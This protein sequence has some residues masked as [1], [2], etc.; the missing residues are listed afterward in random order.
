MLK[1]HTK[2]NI[3]ILLSIIC[4]ISIIFIES[5]LPQEH[6]KTQQFTIQLNTNKILDNQYLFLIGLSSAVYLII[7]FLGLFSLIKFI[8]YNFKKPLFVFPKQNKS[9]P[10]SQVS[11]SQ[12]IFLILFI[13]LFFYLIQWL[14]IF[15]KLKINLIGFNLSANFLV[16]TIAILLLI[17]YLTTGY[18]NFKLSIANVTNATRKYLI[19][20]PVIIGTVL[21]N[22]FVLE[23]IGIEIS[24]NPAIELF[25]KIK[26]LLWLSVLTFQIVILGPIAEELFF[27]GFIYKLLRKRCGFL[28]SAAASSVLFA[29]LHRSNEDI[30]PISVLAIA[31][32]YVY[33]KTNDITSP[34]LLH[35]IHNSLSVS[36]L[37]LFKI[38]A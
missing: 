15:F 14:I 28:V 19:I 10:L 27:R 12:L 21:I 16:E 38:L 32:C 22:N 5:S 18:L 30:L 2:R 26:S 6:K 13:I 3:F 29:A 4:V 35:V 37:L 9:L 17:K 24:V 20:L 34:I 31:L 23:K 8:I 11:A 1:P 7:I 36:F 25:L 33:E